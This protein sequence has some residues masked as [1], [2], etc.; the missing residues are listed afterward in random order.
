VLRF[1][2]KRAEHPR[3]KG[4]IQS[5]VLASA[6]LLWV[7][8]LPLGREAITDPILVAI[9]ILGAG[10]LATRKVESIWVILG[11]ATIYLAAASLRLVSGL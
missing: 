11:S 3:A 8:A 10:V 5:V 9:L 7:A 6:A 4:V 1:L 2:G